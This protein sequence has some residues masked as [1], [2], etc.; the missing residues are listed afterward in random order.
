MRV[1]GRDV[2]RV[3]AQLLLH[4][5]WALRRSAGSSSVQPTQVSTRGFDCPHFSSHLL[6]SFPLRTLFIYHTRLPTCLQCK[7]LS[8]AGFFFRTCSCCRLHSPSPV[9][10]STRRVLRPMPVTLPSAS[11]A[12]WLHRDWWIMTSLSQSAPSTTTRDS[13][14]S[15]VV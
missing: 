6:P 11:T 4:L 5:T 15:V 12:N 7:D 8:A 2:S 10:H 9:T 3:T 13:R 1:S 14:T